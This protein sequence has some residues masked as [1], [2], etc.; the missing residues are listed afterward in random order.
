M[1]VI[2]NYPYGHDASDEGGETSTYVRT[3]VR[4]Y[5]RTYVRTYVRKYVR[6]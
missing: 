3:Y 6:T 4:T 2:R 5:G 1:N